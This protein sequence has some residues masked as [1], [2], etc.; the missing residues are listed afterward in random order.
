MS[1]ARALSKFGVCS[2]REAE[3]WI[4]EGRV[5]VEGAVERSPRRRIDPRRDRVTVDGRRVGDDVERVVIAFHKPVGLVTTRVDPG[6]R[7]TVYDALSGICR[8]GCFRSAGST[9]TAPGC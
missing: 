1:L 3:R 6:G 5:R 2:R 7:P 8:A 9:A 4:A